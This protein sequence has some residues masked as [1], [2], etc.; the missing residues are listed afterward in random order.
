MAAGTR[1]GV[2]QIALRR[3]N[4]GT[5]FVVLP[6]RLEGEPIAWDV[7]GL[8][9]VSRPELAVARGQA[10]GYLVVGPPFRAAVRAAETSGGG[11]RVRL[12][13]IRIAWQLD[14]T[15][16]GAATFDVESGNAAECPLSLPAG[17]RLI[18]TS[19]GGVPMPPLAAGGGWTC[20][21]GPAGAAQRVEVVFDGGADGMPDDETAGQSPGQPRPAA[22][23]R[24]SA[25]RCHFPRRRGG[26]CVPHARATCGW[27]KREWTV[28]GPALVGRGRGGGTPGRRQCEAGPTGR[29]RGAVGAGGVVVAGVVGRSA[30]GDCVRPSRDAQM[31]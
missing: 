3:V 16:H 4:A 18:Q 26:G 6:T 21:L 19:V 14:G 29:R 7:Q 31:R 8:Q 17:F 25:R 12:A 27:T 1:V 13:D 2:P 15:C 23:S 20:R 5:R 10:A 30:A 9:A 11:G 24:P 22:A 28:A